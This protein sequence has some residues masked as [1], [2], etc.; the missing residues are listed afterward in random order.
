[1]QRRRIHVN[2]P[3]PEGHAQYYTGFEKVLIQAVLWTCLTGSFL[4]EY[5][6]LCGS[7]GQAKGVWR[8]SCRQNSQRKLLKK[9]AVENILI[10]LYNISFK[11]YVFTY[12]LSHLF[13]LA[14]TFHFVQNV[15]FVTP[16]LQT[17]VSVCEDLLA[18]FA[19]KKTE[20]NT[21]FN[22][23]TSLQNLYT[24]ITYCSSD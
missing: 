12:S 13:P 15:K 2:S 23:N 1:M 24:T 11:L 17:L 3:F 4:F 19:H 8:Y 5:R 22:T 7:Q 16:F 9:C 14:F 20:Y 18:Y 10:L 21:K 6:V